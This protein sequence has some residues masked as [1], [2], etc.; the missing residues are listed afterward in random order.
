[1]WRILAGRLSAALIILYS[2]G[3]CAQDFPIRSMRMVTGPPGGTGDFAARLIAQGLS[4]S[5]GQQVVVENQ[6]A[7]VIPAQLVAKATPDGYT[8]FFYGSSLWTLELLQSVPYETVRDFLPIT[9]TNRLPNIL[10]VHPS[11]PVNS[12]AELIALAKARPGK[13]N[14]A[15]G[16]I[17]G[18]DHLSMELFKAMTG[19]NITQI[20]YRGTGPAII[21][22]MANE[23]QLSISPAAAVSP[24]LKS[25][26]LRG[27][28]V[29][30][31]HPS[32][33]AAGLPT[34]AMTVP[35]YE[36]T[37]L[38]GI[39][40]PARTPAILINRLN[41]EIVRFISRTEVKDQFLAVGADT[42][43]SSPEE[44]ASVIGADIVKW[45]KVIKE[46]GIRAN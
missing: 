35:G 41:Q 2:F 45:T 6:P 13:L 18:T 38:Y 15:M 20:P 25:G 36:F 17:G 11:S 43:G 5:L 14:Y 39:W 32:L 10:V 22:L 44:F 42:V 40:A 37:A 4:V 31:A 34:V 29:T 27:L 26:R 7:G 8:L 21:A 46:A 1:M 30:S 23:A 16:G 9:L 3:V 12:V 28:A 24:H 33:L 19:V